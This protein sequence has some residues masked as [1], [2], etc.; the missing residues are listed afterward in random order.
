MEDVM[1]TAEIRAIVESAA[2]HADIDKALA[3]VQRK[4]AVDGGGA[5]VGEAVGDLAAVLRADADHECRRIYPAVRRNVTGGCQL[6]AHGLRAH[7]YLSR[8]LDELAACPPHAPQYGTL[9][10]NLR[11][12]FRDHRSDHEERLFV[13]L[14][15]A[16]RGERRRSPSGQAGIPAP[17]AA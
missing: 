16:C 15:G 3:E 5:R 4:V 10:G 13:R 6:V 9:L 2:R 8:C 11:V 12:A 14:R 1:A 17:R 7:S